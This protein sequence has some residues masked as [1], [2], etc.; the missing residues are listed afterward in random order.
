MTRIGPPGGVGMAAS[1]EG[2]NQSNSR[3]KIPLGIAAMSA[4]CPETVEEPE[5]TT[6]WLSLS[7]SGARAD[8]GGTSMVWRF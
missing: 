7:G 1:A 4:D 5:L 3:L 8:P 2:M 6:I